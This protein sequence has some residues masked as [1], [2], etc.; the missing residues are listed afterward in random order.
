[1]TPARN[2]RSLH[3]P[4]A[5]GPAG[6]SFAALA[7]AIALGLAAAG[8]GRGESPHVRVVNASGRRLDQLWVCTQHDSTRVPSLAPGE[9]VVVRPRVHGEDLLWLSGR[10]AGRRITSDGGD[11]VEG[12]AGYRFRA[13]VDSTGHAQVRF[14]RMAIW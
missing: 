7:L 1:M 14:I 13:V 4:R 3:S 2:V 6:L 8:C 9:S 10:F 12:S 5:A 11:Y